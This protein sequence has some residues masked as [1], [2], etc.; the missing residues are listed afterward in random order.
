MSQKTISTLWLLTGF[1]VLILLI[2]TIGLTIKARNTAV[3]EVTA[4]ISGSKPSAYLRQS[5]SE[6]SKILTIIKRGTAISI[7]YASM[8]NEEN[9]YHIYYEDQNGWIPADQ[10]SLA[11]P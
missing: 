3:V 6:H 7:N 9:W 5:P 4:Y 1:A 10:I 2:A 8:E 11:P